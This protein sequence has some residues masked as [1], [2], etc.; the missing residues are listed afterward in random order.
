[1][2]P[3]AELP[4][5]SV[6]MATYNG[7]R[8]IGAQLNS[9]LEQTYP[10]LELIIVDDG[11]TDGTANLLKQYAE[12]F[13]NIRLFFNEQNI[14]Y[15]RNF[16]KGMLLAAGDFLALSDQDDIWDKQK[17]RLLMQE[18]GDHPVVYCNSELIDYNGNLTGKKLSDIKRLGDFDDCLSFL[19]GNSAPG[20]AM[21]IRR[22]LVRASVPLA[23][24][25]PHDH[26]LGFVATL[27]GKIKF[28][29]KVLVQYRQHNAN[30][31]GAAK[32][33]AEGEPVPAKK[34]KPGKE[35]ELAQI[36]ERMRL[37]YEKCP[38]SLVNEKKIL[39]DVMQSYQDFSL[40]NNFKR[41][42][43][44]FRYNRRILAY[45]RRNQLRRWLFC[46]KMFYKIK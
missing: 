22:S 46:L 20:H 18:I 27:T 42:I 29:D 7:E 32:V 11:S 1:M 13:N 28:V 36:R 39:A 3:A 19:V 31:F 33:K 17:L 23:P 24:M 10:N 30:V 4:L 37:Q 41:M 44:F 35:T 38:E 12:R 14:G 40:M 6:V 21:I 2:N 26:W 16:E 8:F 25:I 9:I 45:K 34:K 5:V 15:V 43:L